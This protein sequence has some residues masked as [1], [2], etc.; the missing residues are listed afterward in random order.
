ML[1]IAFLYAWYMYKLVA[2]QRFYLSIK[3]SS[4][5]IPNT[6]VDPLSVHHVISNKNTT[7]EELLRQTVP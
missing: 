4:K 2:T 1:N 5:C 3:F 7:K 6:I